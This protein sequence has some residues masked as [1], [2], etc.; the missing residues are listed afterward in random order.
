MIDVSEILVKTEQVI[1]G[2]A[3]IGLILLQTLVGEFVGE[4]EF[5]HLFDNTWVDLQVDILLDLV[6][7]R[8]L[9]TRVDRG[10][11]G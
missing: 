9:L 11:V 5:T 10:V 3:V 7:L 6:Q 1:G 8:D 2:R 4:A